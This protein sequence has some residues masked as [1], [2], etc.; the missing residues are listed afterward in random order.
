M[1]T[2]GGRGRGTSPGLGGRSP[3][4]RQHLPPV[5]AP[6]VRAGES[7]V[8]DA[9]GVTTR[10]DS[11]APSTRPA[12]ASSSGRESGG[13]AGA[14]LTPELAGLGELLG[15]DLSGVRVLVDSPDL[16]TPALTV[17]DRIRFAP[18]AYDPAGPDGLRLLAHELVHVIQQAGGTG[19]TRHATPAAAEAEADR[20]AGQVLAGVPAGPIGASEP[21]V[22][23]AAQVVIA[24]Q[25]FRPDPNLLN[26]VPEG[27]YVIESTWHGDPFRLT[28][29]RSIQSTTGGGGLITYLKIDIVYTGG[30]V[31]D[32]GT[33]ELSERTP[34]VTP[35]RRLAPVVTLGPDAGGDQVRYNEL[36]LD[37]FGDG[38]YRYL[39]DDST[40]FEQ[41][42]TPPIRRHTFD[43]A[44]VGSHRDPM[45]SYAPQTIRERGALPVADAAVLEALLALPGPETSLLT[46]AQLLYLAEQRLAET[47]PDQWAPGRDAWWYD[48]ARRDLVAAIRRV[49]G[50]TAPP[51]D[52]EALRR[53][54]TQVIR[55]CAWAAPALRDLAPMLRPELYL[56]NASTEA[57]RMVERVIAAT[58]SA[59]FTSWS[60]RADLMATAER[61]AIR[62]R[63]ALPYELA[64][65]Y[66]SSGRGIDAVQAET[67]AV[68]GDLM[69]WRDKG[70]VRAHRVMDDILRIRYGSGTM[71]PGT[72]ARE[73]DPLR[74][75]FITSGADVLVQLVD[76]TQHTQRE[77]G[78]MSLFALY[79][80]LAWFTSELDSWIDTAIGVVP[81]TNPAQE[82]V[83]R[84]YRDQ[85]AA[86]LAEIEAAWTGT[87]TDAFRATVDAVIGRFAEVATG[88]AFTA[89]VA[90][91]DSRLGSIAVVR[92]VGKVLVLLA[93]ASLAGAAA[94]SMAG[95]ALTGL[96]R[97]LAL[98]A[99]TTTSIARAGA[100][101]AEVTVFTAVN[102]AGSAAM[103][104]PN[105]T[106]F[107]EDFGTNFV[108]F[109]L[110]RFTSRVYAARW[111]ALRRLAQPGA[112]AAGQ[113]GTSLVTL[114]IFAEMHHLLKS[115]GAMSGEER[116]Q[117]VFN[118]VVLVTAF[119]LG[120]HI[121]RSPESRLAAPVLEHVRRLYG[122]RFRTLEARRTE[123]ATALE[124]ARRDPTSV[125]LG[126][127]LR[128]I[129]RC[130]TPSSS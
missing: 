34:A 80:Q 93:V 97:A 69:M 17:R 128:E 95:T 115:G 122:S 119:S 100:F 28:V 70:G 68:S 71:T 14:P 25:G 20:V 55:V 21:G 94:G 12:E 107:L 127:L 16:T 32:R 74:E 102:R 79:A 129:D 29:R 63:L 15:A 30:H 73:L 23:Q 64:A 8:A 88:P 91:F 82:P 114:Q 57:V 113:A 43:G 61:N 83:A 35:D 13:T 75:A 52:A 89:A 4:R 44:E 130:T 38:S 105:R 92:I 87:W 41:A 18:G 36:F 85:F 3:A 40:V 22:P 5:P 2:P 48:S 72:R 6:A 31:I 123:L 126:E 11:P 121:A 47:H 39:I 106:T 51:A 54:G 59:V 90:D 110:L 67:R 7:P 50:A 65:L 116:F 10:P 26:P 112:F 118:N 86:M 125:D 58:V 117:A 99:S 76:L 45:V 101:L 103:I 9:A 24:S 66:L 81:G 78:L 33:K 124:Q 104:G 49:D 108:L 96:G 98:S 60:D 109:R 62:A 19:A 120:G 37:V 46:T 42:W 27:H 111:T 56:G 53:R 77:A 84:R 1:D